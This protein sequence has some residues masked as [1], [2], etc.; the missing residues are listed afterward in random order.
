MRYNV[1]DEYGR[2]I[3]EDVGL[4]R[5]QATV[6]ENSGARLQI[7]KDQTCQLRLKLR[8]LLMEKRR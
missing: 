6:R 3:D 5:A 4:K 8:K 7:I 1:I 2:L